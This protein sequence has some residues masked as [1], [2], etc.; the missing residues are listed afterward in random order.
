MKA[1]AL[2]L[3]F[4]SFT[5]SSA[6]ETLEF[7]FSDFPPFE[8]TDNGSSAGINKEIIEEAC[9]RLGVTPVFNQLPWKRALDYAKE[10]KADAIFSLFKNDERTRYYNFPQENINTVRM[11]LISNRESRI[12]ITGLEDLRGK[13]VGVYLGS[14]YGDKFDAADWIIKET[15]TTNESHLRKQDAGRTDVAVMD[16]RVAK[17]WCKKIGME[18]RF[19]VHSYRLTENPTYVS[20]SKVKAEKTGKNWAGRFSDVF[21]E[22][23]NE[24]FIERINKKYMF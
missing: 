21:K 8:Y 18:K 15:A 1:C 6:A 11:V 12:E 20:F 9:R 22:M 10:G 16:E 24:R 14:S 23:K 13:K 19:S 4:M 3:L 2:F 7:V 17:Y 5:S